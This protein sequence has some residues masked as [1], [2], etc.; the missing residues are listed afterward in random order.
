[1]TELPATHLNDW[2]AVGRVVALYRHPIK[3]MAAQPLSSATIDHYGIAGDRRFALKRRGDMSGFPWLTASKLP[4]L[5]RYAVCCESGEAPSRARM[6]VHAPSGDFISCDGDDFARHFA[7]AHGVDVELAHLRQGIFDLAGLSVL[8][9]QTLASLETMMDMR[10]DVRRFRPNVVIDTGSSAEPFPEDA[11]VGQSLAFGNVGSGARA[12][13]TELDERC[14]MINFDPDTGVGSPNV[15]RTVVRERNNYAG[16]YAVP[17][18][19]GAIA[20][21]DVAYLHVDRAS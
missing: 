11:W 13:V 7:E 6:H 17:T 18:R 12:S 1:V 14:V 21:G 8:T 3:S 19:G 16:V 10:L 4:A 9:A 20:V 5:I 15:L 2:R